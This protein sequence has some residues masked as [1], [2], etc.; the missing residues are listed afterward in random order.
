[1]LVSPEQADELK[2]ITDAVARRG[3]QDSL[4][5]L[6]TGRYAKIARPWAS[7][8]L[9]DQSRAPRAPG[10]KVWQT[11]DDYARCASSRAAHLQASTAVKSWAPGLPDQPVRSRAPT[12]ARTRFGG[13]GN[14]PP[15]AIEIIAPHPHAR[16]AWL[17][18]MYRISASFSSGQRIP[19]KSCTSPNPSRPRVPTCSILA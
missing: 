14:R 17:L 2:P 10:Y 7:A 3:R 11:I 6:H 18:L 15:P 12:T 13:S 19:M 5:V 9:S 8:I 4:R 1:M 16:G